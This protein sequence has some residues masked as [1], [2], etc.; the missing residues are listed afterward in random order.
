M[1]T[2]LALAAFVSAVLAQAPSLTDLIASQPDLSTLGTAL[3][4]LPDL[5]KALSGLSNITILAPTNSAFELLLAQESTPESEAISS[6]DAQGIAAILAY[7]VLNGTYVSTDFS[8]TPA[9]VNSLFMPS[10]EG[11]IRTNVTDGQNVGLMLKGENATILSAGMPANVIEAVSGPTVTTPSSELTTPGH[12][13]RQRRCRPQDRL[14]PHG[15]PQRLHHPVQ[16]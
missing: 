8:E 9:F 16:L 14:R 6:S 15:P 2:S 12:P 11:S 10:L 13:S 1:R 5:V 7:H 3:G 4:S